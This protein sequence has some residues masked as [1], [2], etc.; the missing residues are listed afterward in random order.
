MGLTRCRAPG[1]MDFLVVDPTFNTVGT[2]MSVMKCTAF[3]VQS[4]WQS[5]DVV[6]LRRTL[7]IYIL[8]LEIGAYN[9]Y[10]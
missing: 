4:F 10:T 2:R 5:G 3:S 6:S 7:I 8:L 9:M 1:S